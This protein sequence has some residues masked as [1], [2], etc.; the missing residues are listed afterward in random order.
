VDEGTK[1]SRKHQLDCGLHAT[2]PAVLLW[3]CWVG[4]Q[5]RDSRVL[6]MTVEQ[7]DSRQLM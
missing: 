1:G 5:G 4:R 3:S 7:M 6:I 2:L